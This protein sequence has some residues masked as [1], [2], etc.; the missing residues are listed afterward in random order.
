MRQNEIIWQLQA[1]LK[2]VE[3]ENLLLRKNISELKDKL[4]KSIEFIK[5]FTPDIHLPSIS[6]ISKVVT[7]NECLRDSLNKLT[8]PVKKHTVRPKKTKS[9]DQIESDGDYSSDNISTAIKL[10]TIKYHFE[11]HK[12]RKL[13]NQPARTN[14]PPKSTPNPFFEHIGIGEEEGVIEYDSKYNSE[15]EV[16]VENYNRLSSYSL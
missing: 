11:K 6:V 2:K 16:S 13:N 8:V 10:L 3:K 1:K 5:N 12:E 9:F 14:K 7:I 15:D 4:N